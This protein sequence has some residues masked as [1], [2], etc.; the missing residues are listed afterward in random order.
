MKN[1]AIRVNGEQIR[2]IEADV[3]AHP[4]T[5]GKFIIIRKGKKNYFSIEVK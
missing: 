3:T 4:N 5:D 1:G 2:D